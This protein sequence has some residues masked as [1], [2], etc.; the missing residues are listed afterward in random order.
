MS[1]LPPSPTQ[2]IDPERRLA[3]TYSG[4]T[5]TGFH[6]DSVASALY[7]GG[8][9]IFSRSIKYHRPRG[10]YSL[11]GESSN[12]LVEID[13]QPNMRA[14]T[15]PLRGG[16]AVKPQNVF[17]SAEWD[18]WGMMDK[19]DW[20][21]PAGFYYR[22]FHKPYDMWPFFLNRIRQAAGIGKLSPNWKGGSYDQ[23]LLNAEVCI[24]G[25]GPAG[26][27]A[28]LAAS[29]Y[30]LRV[31]LIEARP[32]LGGF[33]DWR[34]REYA[35]GLPLHSRA[36][37]MAAEA[38]KVENLRIFRNTFVNG[39]WGDNL[40]TGFQIG[41]AQDAFEERYIEVRAES[42]VVATG[43]IERP[44]IF[45]NNDRPGVMQVGCAHR[46]AM[47]YGILPGKSAVFSV[48]QDLGLE[49]ALDLADLGMKI[50]AVADCRMDGHEPALVDALAERGIPFLVGCAASRAEGDR[51]V[52]GVVLTSLDGIERKRFGCQ[53]L[54]A[55]AGMTPAAGPLAVTQAKMKYDRHTN[56]FLPEKMPARVHAAGRLL[57]YRDPT[58]IES[59]GR[60]AGLA[61][62]LDCRAPAEKAYREAAD[63]L[64]GGRG[65]G[66]GSRLPIAP[67]IGAGN[68][69][70]ICFD[71]DTTVKHIAQA[72]QHG[73]DL[74]ELAKRFTAIGTGPGQGG[75]PGHNLPLLLSLFRGEEV[76]EIL[77]TNV[78]PPLVPTLMATYAGPGYDVFKQTPLHAAQARAG[79]V[80]RRVGP[81][82]RARYF[83]DDLSSRREITAVHENVGLIDVSTLGKF[84]LFGPDAVQ[85][86]Q[87]IFVGDMTRIPQDR[88]KYAAMCNDDGCLID[89]G[90]IVRPGENDYYFTTTTG[91]AGQTLEWFRYH[92]RYENWTYHL[93][94]L[95]DAYGT[96]NLAGPK[97][98]DLLGRLT[99]ADLSHEAFPYLG[100]REITLAGR[101][102]ARVMRLG[103]VGELSYEIHVPA[104]LTRFVWDLLLEA[105]QEFPVEPFGLE[106]QNVL[107]LEKG[108]ILIGQDTEIRVTLHDLGLGFLW[109]RK[110]KEARTV[111]APAL[112]FTEL[113]E[114]RL[115]LVGFRMEN[116]EETPGEGAII[117][118]EAVRGHITSSRLSRVLG[119]S[120]GL[121]L[122]DAPLAAEGTEL[123]IF[124]AGMGGRRLRA[125][126]VSRPFYDPEGKRL[127]M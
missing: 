7:A 16:M 28:A 21:M 18:L 69:S 19:L 11:D 108:H 122:V 123:S 10:L 36:A 126:V 41:R 94:D 91:R 86:L 53:L 125:R 47:T 96:V 35:P 105:G 44:L 37:E 87:R 81:W 56:F 58:A 25:G 102:P 4:R 2:R 9:R 80:F 31:V 75:I 100:F 120:I 20:A 110:K 62:A 5:F 83:S 115:K 30:G 67:G 54:V 104:S 78:R 43:C 24:L 121:A 118:D 8:V 73:F 61:A 112:R 23:L 95:T 63:A 14:A 66:K 13:G 90:V 106:A 29:A 33:Y 117:V 72:C 45:E 57:G 93:V 32:W 51:G 76:D 114:D 103:F 98:R 49:A 64:A 70:F 50:H 109:D 48:G 107:R 3:F 88:V 34:K 40:V 12:C 99:D 42:V 71:E 77:P 113:Q 89:D 26:L 46:L 116:P 1:R 119:Q 39:L 68:K 55:S 101:V 84:R 6:G 38:D 52:T 65:P 82:K 17:G 111:G 127:R 15:T 85:A 97:A 74:P 22:A 60:V 27:S 79:A 59:S 92:T 124:E